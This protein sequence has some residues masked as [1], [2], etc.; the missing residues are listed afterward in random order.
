MIRTY[1]QRLYPTAKQA[2][3]MT[4]ILWS[5]CWLYNQALV[6]RRKRWRESRYSVSYYE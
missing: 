1:K 4:D 5:G 3:V 6:Y 2:S